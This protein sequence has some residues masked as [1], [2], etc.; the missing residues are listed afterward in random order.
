[1]IGQSVG[2]AKPLTN[3]I[4]SEEMQFPFFWKSRFAGWNARGELRGRID[5]GS[6]GNGGGGQRRGAET[7]VWNDSLRTGGSLSAKPPIIKK[8]FQFR[9]K[10]SRVGD[11]VV[12]VDKQHGWAREQILRKPLSQTTGGYRWN[13]YRQAFFS[14]HALW[15]SKPIF[16]S[17]FKFQLEQVLI[18]RTDFVCALLNY[19][20]GVGISFQ[21]HSNKIFKPCDHKEGFLFRFFLS[22]SFRL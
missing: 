13:I 20:E 18:M 2:F 16:G 7:T 6:K 9:K 22:F 3:R 17:N 19:W 10:K 4:I 14:F 15:L 11:I 21:R 5:G 1:M 8:Q 12:V